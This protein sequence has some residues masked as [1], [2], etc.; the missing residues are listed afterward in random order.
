MALL[1]GLENC[2][3]GHQSLYN[4]GILH[5]DIPINIIFNEDEN[6]HSWPAFLIDLDLAIKIERDGA[7]GANGKTGTIAFMA[8]GSL[9][10]ENHSF[11][12]DLESFFWVI[13]WLFIHYE[14]PGDG[15]VVEGFTR[16]NFA[17]TEELADLNR[18]AVSDEADFVLAAKEYFKD[19][20]RPLILCVN[21][22][23]KAVCPHGRRWSKE[24]TGL[25]SRMRHARAVLTA[26]ST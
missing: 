3:S 22:L 1:A 6:N 18:G 14:G 5:R 8:I 16:W 15:R 11:M 4:A 21:V 12:H 20:Y 7:T 23:L 9:K 24:D 26:F 10:E 17:D 2:I 19:Y 25:Y 13:F